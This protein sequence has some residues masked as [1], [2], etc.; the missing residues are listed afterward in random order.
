MPTR[1]RISVVI[2]TYNRAR[3]VE[4][5]VASALRAID[6]GDEIIVVD[7]GSVDDTESVL[8]QFGSRIRYLRV[9]NGGPGKARNHGIVAARNPLIAFLD[10]DDEWL[11]DKI[12]LQRSLMAALPELVFTFSTFLIRDD[13]SGQ[14]IP[15]GLATH[16]LHDPPSWEAVLGEGVP[17]SSIAPLPAGRE[18]FLVYVGDMYRPLLEQMYVAASTA[19][20]RRDLAGE[21]FRFAE[22]LRICEDWTCFAQ[23]SRRGPAAYL[24]CATALNHGHDGPRL[25]TEQGQHGLLSARLVVTGRIWGN[26]PE[27]LARYGAQYRAVVDDLHQQRARWLISHGRTREAREDLRLADHP[28]RP[29]RVLSRLPGSVTLGLGEARRT[30]LK[31]AALLASLL[32]DLP[33]F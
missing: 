27:F 16:W 2:P 29:L 21:V 8:A 18:D 7:D 9:P 3:L 25:T 31:V 20:V 24:H 11:P 26:D 10:S 19:M 23:I 15:D 17:F 4:R 32:T 28:S 1:D 14:E 6:A 12:A 5:A 13:E 30:M 22:D 33:I